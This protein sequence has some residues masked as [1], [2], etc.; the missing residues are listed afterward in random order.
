MTFI[1]V[2]PVADADAE[3][4]LSVALPEESVAEPAVI[5]AVA[6]A[7]AELAV[8]LADPVVP[9]DAPVSL[10]LPPPL[11]PMTKKRTETSA[12]RAFIT[13]LD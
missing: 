1:V 13:S 4:E 5:V 11:H 8:S 12:N 7:V 6:V 9:V 2:D 10:V 3:P